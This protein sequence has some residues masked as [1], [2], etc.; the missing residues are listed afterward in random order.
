LFE[1]NYAQNISIFSNNSTLIFESAL[2]GIAG[3]ESNELADD[4]LKSANKQFGMIRNWYGDRLHTL[5]RVSASES[6]RSRLF[7]KIT[8]ELPE[9]YCGLP[10]LYHLDWRYRVLGR[11]KH[12]RPRRAQ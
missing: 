12:T 3:K 10:L 2:P 5:P 8:P 6:P 9:G 7:R 11:A 1:T 4:G